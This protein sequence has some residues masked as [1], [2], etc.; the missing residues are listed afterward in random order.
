[1]LYLKDCP[2]F[3][4]ISTLDCESCH[5]AKHHRVSLSPRI[6]KRASSAFDLVHSDIWGPSSTV[7]KKG[8]KY[9]VTFVDDHTR[10]TWLY[11]MKNR[12]E[13]FSIFSMFCAE[14]RNQFNVSIKTL[15]S[16]NAK[17][18]M[19]SQFSTYMA[20]YGMLHETSCVDTA[21]QNGVA[22]RKN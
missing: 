17:E 8:Y 11:L 21:A 13:L 9:F 18:Y 14:I 20:K 5:F 12:S 4:S 10:V 15:R 16:D 3:N 2:Q 19:S 1:M 7:S 6:N 22:E